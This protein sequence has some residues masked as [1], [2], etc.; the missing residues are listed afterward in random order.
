MERRMMSRMC[1]KPKINYLLI[2]ILTLSY[3]SVFGQKERKF[4]RQGNKYFKKAIE[5]SDSTKIDSIGFSKAEVEYRK[6]LDKKPGD[7]KSQYNLGNSLFK[8]NKMAEASSQFEQSMSMA[9]EKGDKAKVWYNYGNAMFAQQK[10]DESIEAYKNALRNDPTDIEA[11]YNLEF[12]R[13][14]KQQQEQQQEQ[15]KNEQNKNQDNKQDKQQQ[16]QDNQ[17]QNQDNQQEQQQQPKISKQDAEQMLKALQNDE[18][19]TQEKVKKMEAQ[20]ARSTRPEQD[21]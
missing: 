6:G 17:Q 12:A 3:I 1:L 21:W 18:A 4:V 7:L 16:N 8:Q 19:K 14:M 20:K 13:R 2:I 15:Q 9:L 5:N 11:K 10:F